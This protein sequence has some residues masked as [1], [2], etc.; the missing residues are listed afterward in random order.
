VVCSRINQ[1]MTVL[2]DGTVVSCEQDVYG[3][4][5]MGRVGQASLKEIW[6]HS[7]GELRADHTAGNWKKQ[8]VCAACREWHRP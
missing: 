3:R 6:S 1:R 7:F 4:Q 2:C 5:V 8:P